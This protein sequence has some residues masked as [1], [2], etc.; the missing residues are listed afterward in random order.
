MTTAYFEAVP[1]AFAA[2]TMTGGLWR[3]LCDFGVAKALS[4]RSAMKA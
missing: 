1:G 2:E 3:R 4:P